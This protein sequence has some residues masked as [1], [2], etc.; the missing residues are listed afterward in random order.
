[1]NKN[2]TIQ[3]CG[4]VGMG[5]YGIV[6]K[7]MDQN[8]NNMAVKRID[9]SNEGIPCLMETS[10]MSVI[11]H[12]YLN[13]AIQ[14]HPKSEAVF[15]IQNLADCDLYRWRHKNI[16]SHHQ[17][18]KWIHQLIQAIDCLHRQNIIHGDIKASNVLLFN[19]G[20]IKL[21]DFTLS[22]HN[23]WPN[24]YSCCTF[25][26]RPLEVLL[27]RKWDKSVDIWALGCTI[28]QLIYDYSLFPYQDHKDNNV[29]NNNNNQMRDRFINAILDWGERGPFCKQSL[30]VGY[31]DIN[32]YP[33]SL[34]D[35]F[36]PDSD[37]N[38]LFLSMLIID[39][40]NRPS[41]KQLLFDNPSSYFND[42][43]VIDVNIDIIND[44]DTKISIRTEQKIR[45]NIETYV[46][47][48]FSINNTEIPS[49]Y[50]PMIE[51]S[52]QLYSRILGKF[53]ASDHLKIVT[54]IWIAGKLINRNIIDVSS[55]KI[56]IHQIMEMERTICRHL[57][58]RLHSCNFIESK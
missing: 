36:D 52:Y 54:C 44:T 15:I 47:L 45:K 49:L 18:K 31:R 28:F 1:M 46:K 55:T 5:G 50:I 14:I 48:I 53:V 22:T 19:N 35:N 20:D 21:S 4:R 43:A 17:L 10:I 3:L 27:E 2:I 7:C 41:T 23:D 39:P 30:P 33:F 57:S 9:T 38:K 58:F 34:P 25:T 24:K 26:H 51:L 11:K 29:S 12:P 16:P 56:P 37:I 8:G 40:K 42:L 6:F 32:Y 13:H